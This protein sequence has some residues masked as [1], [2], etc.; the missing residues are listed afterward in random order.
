MKMSDIA[1]K[2]GVSIATVSRVINEDKN[3][4]DST[5]EKILKIIEECDY[6]PS[7]IARNLSRK[8]NNTI[9]VV[10]PDISNPYF[11]EMVEGISEVID[12]ENLNIL[13]YNTNDKIEKEQKSLQMLLEQRIKGLVITVTSESYE[14]GKNYLDKFVK[15]KIPVVLAD[16][17]IKYSSMDCV[18][19]DNIGGAHKG[20]SVLI[21][22]G[23]KEIAI[24][25]G[26]LGSKPGRDRLRGYQN[27]L[28]ENGI[29]VIEGNIYEGD[30]Q[31]ESGYKLGKEILGRKKRPTAVFIS[32]NQM[33][34]GFFKAMNEMKLSTP[35]NIA[36][37]SFDRVEI[38][39]IFDIKLTT[40]S[41]SVRELGMRSAEMLLDRIRSKDK[42]I[43]QKTILQT[44]L[45]IKGSEKNVC[46]KK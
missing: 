6:T 5:R 34:L 2:A 40:V 1:E 3:V 19:I 18:F 21:E 39:D 9:G 25:T 13:I 41:A 16:R 32:N 4:K 12:R 43:S 38:L 10:V 35:K 28:S 14:K 20:V 22:N 33:T 46:R 11:S 8:D 42:D 44:V 7:A 37:L 36:V 17:D 31:M 24:I 29:E 30:F 15:E 27:A 45:D 23:H 26:P